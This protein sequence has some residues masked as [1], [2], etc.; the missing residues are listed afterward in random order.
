MQDATPISNGVSG[1][2]TSLMLRDMDKT[3]MQKNQFDYYYSFPY[4]RSYSSSENYTSQFSFALAPEQKK[5]KPGSPLSRFGT[6]K[7]KFDFQFYLTPSV[8]YRRLVDNAEGT[9]TK[10]YITA[11]PLAANYV[12][13][14]NQVINH[15]PAMG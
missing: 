14:V 7:P 10:S 2:T 6:N 8:S 3:S 5:N 15:R 1:F 11:L 9:L 12:V 4:S 13:D